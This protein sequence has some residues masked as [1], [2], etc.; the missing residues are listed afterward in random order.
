MP[1]GFEADPK[2]GKG[3]QLLHALTGKYFENMNQPILVY[4][5]ETLMELT[6]EEVYEVALEWLREKEVADDYNRNVNQAMGTPNKSWTPDPRKV[7]QVEVKEPLSEEEA[8]WT[9][10]DTQYT[11]GV[12][13][14][15]QRNTRMAGKGD[16]P[17][18]GHLIPPKSI[19]RNG[20]GL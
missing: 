17:S 20:E 8:F 15:E 13:Q 12:N 14:I 11:Q 16:H 18:R 19:V 4:E 2:S 7:R 9:V 5:M 3:S 1:D 6:T 10:G